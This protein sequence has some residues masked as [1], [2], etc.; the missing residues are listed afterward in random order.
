MYEENSLDGK[1]KYTVVE[2]AETF[3][4]S[5]KTVCRHLEPSCSRRQ[6]D[7]STR[8]TTS[9]EQLATQHPRRT[10]YR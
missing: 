1:R 9:S 2:I 4:V 3:G 8:S 5:R 7:K 10:A 6:T